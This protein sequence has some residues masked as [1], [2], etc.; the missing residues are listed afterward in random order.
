MPNAHS[1]N[2]LPTPRHGFL[3]IA[4]GF[5]TL[6]LCPPL[7]AQELAPDSIG[8]CW[9]YDTPDARFRVDVV[10]HGLRV[11]GSIAFLSATRAF[12]AER[13]VGRLSFVDLRSGALSPLSGVPPVV[14]EVD[15]GLLDVIVHPDFASNGLIYYVYAEHT[16][17]G[18]AAVVERAR[19]DGDQLTDRK[20][21]LNVHPYIDNVNQF[22]ARLV[23]EHGFLFIAIGDREL[24]ERAQDLSTDLG[25]VVRLR[26]DGSIPADNPFVHRAGARPEIWSLGHRNSHG[27]A[28]DPRT[29]ALWEHEHGPRGGDEINIIRAGRNYGWPVITYGIEYSGEPVGDGI[30]HRAGMEQPVY[31]YLPS[32]APTGM[33]FYSGRELPRWRNNLFLG[34]LSYGHLNRVVLDGNRVV[35]E[36]RLL[37]DR[38]WRIR[39]VRMGLDGQL[40]LGVES[41]LL[42]R[43][44]RATASNGSSSC[45]RGASTYDPWARVADT[46]VTRGSLIAAY[47]ADARRAVWLPSGS[48]T[49][50]AADATLE[51]D[52]SSWAAISSP[53]PAARLRS[54][55][56]TD[57]GGGVL[58]FGGI[59]PDSARSSESWRYASHHWTQLSGVG[60]SAR[61][62]AS[63]TF[64]L[65]HHRTL[66]WGGAPCTDRVLWSWDGKGWSRLDSAGPP[67]RQNAAIAYD[68][69]TRSVVL[70]GGRD[71]RGHA[72]RDA[73]RWDGRR[74]TQLAPV[75]ASAGTCLVY[76][77]TRNRMLLFATDS[78]RAGAA[79]QLDGAR[80]HRTRPSPPAL[81]D[82]ACV[83]DPHQ[84]RIVLVGRSPGATASQTYFILR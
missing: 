2:L 11:P 29:G 67:A 35:R 43:I 65:D 51:W 20:R 4:L 8:S 7:R 27:L 55:V 1:C 3:A 6:A 64:D 36:E 23:L 50:G 39:E 79:W 18:N 21:L 62:N 80:W 72:I 38:G 45:A 14:G 25:K 31:F 40:Y 26:D 84:D 63:M 73:W 12:V 56:A 10:A 49:H 78:A 47:D 32:I 9:T 42:V 22:G 59:G 13:Q 57:P 33:A 81:A 44:S 48:E 17:S 70:L 41:G 74:W 52:G 15:G 30:T 68:Q 69:S 82:A 58:L 46:P 5:A 77:P 75:R 37:R 83:A 60:P 53:A 66:L 61:S 24:P 34:S 71:C 54:A 28:I 16:D 19:V 76:S